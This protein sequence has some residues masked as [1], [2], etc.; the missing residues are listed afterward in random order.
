MS[1]VADCHDP[2]ALQ[3]T[4][5]LLGVKPSSQFNVAVDL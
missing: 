3:E 2:L 5:F 4:E 1:H